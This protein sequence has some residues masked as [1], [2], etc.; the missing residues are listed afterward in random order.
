MLTYFMLGTIACMNIVY[1]DQLSGA[2]YT[3]KLVKIH[4]TEHQ[5]II[6]P[7]TESLMSVFEPINRLKIA[8]V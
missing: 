6:G 5:E 3:H 4:S 2:A 8:L 1:F 7:E